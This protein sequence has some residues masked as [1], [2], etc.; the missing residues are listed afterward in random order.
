[1]KEK[2]KYI[3]LN[4]YY[5]FLYKDICDKVTLNLWAT[6]A[7]TYIIINVKNLSPFASVSRD[8]S[9]QRK[10]ILNYETRQLTGVTVCLQWRRNLIFK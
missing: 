5:A 8:F 3:N 9:P 2:W 4:K 6:M 10:I 7:T 1:M